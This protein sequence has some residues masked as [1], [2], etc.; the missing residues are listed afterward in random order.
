MCVQVRSLDL[1]CVLLDNRMRTTPRTQ[2][3]AHHAP[4]A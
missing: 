4:G 1:P 3:H 2:L